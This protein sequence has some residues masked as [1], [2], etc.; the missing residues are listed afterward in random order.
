VVNVVPSSNNQNRLIQL[1]IEVSRKRCGRL[2]TTA[3]TGY[4]FMAKETY[5]LKDFLKEFPTD[6][7]CLDAV[8]KKR[9][10]EMEWCPACGVEAKFYKVKGRKCYS[11]VHC[12]HHIY[13]LVGTIFEGSHMPLTDWFYIIYE[14][15]SSRN[16]VSAMEVQRK[17]RCTYR[18]A[19]RMTHQ[20]R[21]LMEQDKDLLTGVVE[22]DEAY[23]GGRRRLA[24]KWKN[25][26][27][28][29][30]VADALGW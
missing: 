16:G 5:T 4:F 1:Y 22:A 29:L 24:T 17:L 11:C 3:H 12:R 30:S 25:K 28:L 18:T 19:L 14:F 26:T 20:I 10:G 23:I 9:Y 7:A 6:D 15:A 21:S 27:P 2:S 13:P 8:F